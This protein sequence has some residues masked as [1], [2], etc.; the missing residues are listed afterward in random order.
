MLVAHDPRRRVRTRE[1]VAKVVELADGEQAVRISCLVHPDDVG[2]LDGLPA[3]SFA[4]SELLGGVEGPNP[5]AG[6]L[7]IRADAAAFDDQ[8]I[9][10]ACELMCTVGRTHGYRLF[11][12][13]GPDEARII[14]DIASAIAMS[15]GYGLATSAIYDGLKHLFRHR[16]TSSRTTPVQLELTTSMPSGEVKAVIQTSDP[17]IAR[18]ALAAYSDAVSALA[19]LP[20]EERP[21][22]EW[23][24]GKRT[25]HPELGRGPEKLPEADGAGSASP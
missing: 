25:W 22:L 12:F 11:Q 5:G 9:A 17:E 15:L 13:M 7:E 1:L 18:A 2:E 21:V 14:L 24:A 16:S 20:R 8:V 3:M 10:R 6:K 19:S 23:D 4:T